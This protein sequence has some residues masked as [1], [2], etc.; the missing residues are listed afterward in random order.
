MCRTYLDQSPS[1][2]FGLESGLDLI[3]AFII[4]NIV[5]KLN[6]IELRFDNSDL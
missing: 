1:T 3:Y 6:I 2:C 4:L 5:I